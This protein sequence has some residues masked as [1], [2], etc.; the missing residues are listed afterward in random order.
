M[1]VLRVRYDG[2]P[3]KKIDDCIEDA[4]RTIGFGYVGSG[5]NVVDDVRDLVFENKEIADEKEDS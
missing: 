4:L 2:K 1:K 3:D 5:Y